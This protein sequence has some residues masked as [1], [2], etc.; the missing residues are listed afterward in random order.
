MRLAAAGDV[1]EDL[2]QAGRQGSNFL[3]GYTRE[4]GH[5]VCID[6]D[7]LIQRSSGIFGA[8]GTGKSFLTRMILAGLIQT[9]PRLV[10]IF[11]MH[12]EY[13]P[14]DTA[15]DTGEHVTGL[16]GPSSRPRAAW[17]ALGRAPPSAARRPISTSN[18][19]K[20]ISS[21]RISNC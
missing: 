2:R 6:L 11:D 8:T 5:P 16:E 7:K 9:G 21:L 19:P 20:T 3:I 12:N 17:S 4:Q 15:A 1:A 18:S 13:G 10:L 14:D